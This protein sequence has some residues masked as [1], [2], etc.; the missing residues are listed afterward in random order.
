MLEALF[1]DALAGVV[2]CDPAG[3]V[4]RANAAAGAVFGVAAPSLAG[5][6]LADLLDDYEAIAAAAAASGSTERVVRVRQPAGAP[7]WV[8]LRWRRLDGGRSLVQLLDFSADVRAALEEADRRFA[9]AFDSAPIGMALVGLDGRLLQVNRQLCALLGHRA[10]ELQARAVHDL[11][12]PDDMDRARTHFRQLVEGSLQVASAE[13]RYLTA[14]GRPVW[15]RRTAS[16]VRANSGEPLHLIVQIEDTSRE[17]EAREELARLAYSDPLTGLGNRAALLLRSELVLA[18]GPASLLLLDLD[19]FKRVNDSLGHHVGDR[20]LQTFAT[21]LASVASHE[22]LVVRLGGDEFVVLTRRVRPD[23]LLELGDAVLAA[24]ERP[25][26]MGGT[27]LDLGVSIGIATGERADRIG[28]L[29]RRADLSLYSAKRAG[30]ARAVIFDPDHHGGAAEELAMEAALRRAVAAGALGI[31]Y[32]PIYRL[33]DGSMAGA[34]A[35]C[36]WHD[37]ERGAITPERFISVAEDTGVIHELGELVLR[38]ACADMAALCRRSGRPLSVAVNVSVR[39][40]ERP[41][42]PGLVADALAD[43]GLP[44][45][46]L[47][48]EVT[49]SA[50]AEPGGQVDAALA[51]LHAMGVTLAVDDFGTRYS[52]LGRLR[53]G[54]FELLKIDR[55]FVAEITGDD[56]TSVLAAAGVALGHGLGALVLAE[57]IETPE[58][59]RR[60]R[61]LGCDL[62]QGFLLGAPTGVARLE[63]VAGAACPAVE[64]LGVAQLGGP[65]Q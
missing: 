56:A 16:L 18:E 44:A 9:M 3:V 39:Q 17:R 10:E 24:A 29:L 51:E 53:D 46:A 5:R 36:R 2:V 65:A 15:V 7:H 61:E 34:E 6:Q 11:V 28:E 1:D 23:A 35:L 45:R 59:L 25:F 8:Q 42:F 13:Q 49:E 22:E 30:K 43:A 37:D 4:Q 41:Q 48:L 63:A 58:Q 55:S 60:M 38:R 54:P 32:Q 33:S 14:A 57:G 64:A 62:G 40:L 19:D 26:E 52:S 27:R 20:M 12:H 50:V 21:R 31:E 47:V